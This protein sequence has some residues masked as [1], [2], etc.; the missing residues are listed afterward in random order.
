M[1]LLIALALLACALKLVFS[2][3]GL[4]DAEE[5]HNMRKQGDAAHPNR[6]KSWD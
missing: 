2:V 5:L 3:L 4:N 6:D 1:E